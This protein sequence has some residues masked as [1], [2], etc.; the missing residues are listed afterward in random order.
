MKTVVILCCGPGEEDRVLIAFSMQ[1]AADK[2]MEN[3]NVDFGSFLLDW[4][5]KT[6]SH[7]LLLG[8]IGPVALVVQK[9]GPQ[10]RFLPSVFVVSWKE[11]E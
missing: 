11:D 6:N 2:F 4:T 3:A 5:F 1:T 7:G 8:S 9:H 10:M